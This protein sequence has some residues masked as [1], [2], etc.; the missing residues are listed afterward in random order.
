MEILRT[1][2]FYTILIVIFVIG[3]SLVQKYG[4]PAI[5]D[6]LSERLIKATETPKPS[7]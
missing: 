4:V 5:A 7:L 1:T 6:S 3:F 2:L